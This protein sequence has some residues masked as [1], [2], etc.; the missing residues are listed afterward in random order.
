MAWVLDL[1]GVIWTG[2]TPIEGAAAAVAE[3][4]RRDDVV[5]VTNMSRLVIA[6]QEAKLGAHGI[7]A[8]GQVISSATAAGRLV[9]PGERVFV[10][11]GPG[12]RESVENRGA[13]VI[14]DPR[15]AI[16]ACIVGF[17]P[18][19]DFEWMKDATTAI[20]RGARFIGTNHD[21]T[22]PTEEGLWPGAGAI[23]E[24]VA[25]ATG[26]RP[27]Y[28]GKPHKAVVDEVRDRVGNSGVVVGDR[29]DTDGAFAR[30]L[31]FDFALVLSGVANAEDLH[32]PVPDS[33]STTL[34]ALVADLR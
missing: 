3:L 23:I 27:I 15:A 12:V 32:D 8:R 18:D 26:Q 22:Y 6:D 25:T 1:D 34:A 21:P 9:E 29:P 14:D 10:C 2:N 33:I 28:A 20:L 31:G 17:D 7:E 19:F 4:Q 30:A 11:G 5:F 24:S 13:T 16:D